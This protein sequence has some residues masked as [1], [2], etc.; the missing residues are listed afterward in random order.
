MK[1]I[2]SCMYEGRIRHRRRLPRPRRFHYSLFMMYLDLEELPTLFQ[3]RWLWSTTRPAPARFR[4]SDH[5]GDP[6]RPLADEVRRLV[7]ER[8]GLELRGPVR[9]LTHLRYFGYGMN[10]VSFYFCFDDGGEDL[11][12]V[13]AEVNNT[14]W[15]ERHCY[16]LAEPQPGSEQGVRLYRS[17]KEFHV[18]PFLPMDMEYRWR[19]TRPGR[20]LLVH[21]QNFRRG[22]LCFDATLDLQRRP[23]SGRAL[24]GALI[25]FPFMTLSVLGGIYYQALRLWLARAPFF[26]HPNPEKQVF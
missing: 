17:G 11:E 13:V 16:V 3:G 22:E 14:P 26:S 5:L 4:R 7:K 6:R 18:S 9:L 8:S 15:G 10:P 19:F 2:D 25:R 24:N 20:R 23:V 21:I 1:G 12:A